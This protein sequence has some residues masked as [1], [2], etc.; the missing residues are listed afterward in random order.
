MYF[1]IGRPQL[2][3]RF[4]PVREPPF[5][6]AARRRGFSCFSPATSS[7]TPFN[8][9]AR[10]LEAARE[11]IFSTTR[12]AVVRMFGERLRRLDAVE[13]LR[14]PL[15]VLLAADLAGELLLLPRDEEEE[16]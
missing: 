12:L 14:L 16:D 13:L 4:D 1:A 9:P 2:D 3:F 6:P 7:A 11:A 15:F 8:A 5:E 10:A